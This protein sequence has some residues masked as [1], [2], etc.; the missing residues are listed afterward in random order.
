[1]MVYFLEDI[2]E[3]EKWK[4]GEFICEVLTLK[5]FKVSNI[6][7]PYLTHLHS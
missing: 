4:G 1:M 6:T 2:C 7:Q 3:N 5:G